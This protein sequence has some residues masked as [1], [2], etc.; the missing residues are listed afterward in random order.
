VAADAPRYLTFRA[1]GILQALPADA[2]REVVKLPALTRVPHAPAGMVGLANVRGAAVPIL[3]PA[4]LQGRADASGERLI[5]LDRAD[6][7]GLLVDEVREIVDRK[8][9]TR[10]LDVEA[11]VGLAL[12]QA[13][14]RVVSAKARVVASQRKAAETAAL[15]LISFDVGGQEFALPLDHVAEVIAMP[16]GI[17]PL[18]NADRAVLGS[19]EHRGALLPILALAALLGLGEGTGETAPR[20]VIAVVRGHRVGLAVKSMKSVLRVDETDIDPVPTV[21]ARRVSEA[22]I[23]AIARIESGRRLVSILAVDQL[24][25]ETLMAHMSERRDD[26]AKGEAEMAVEEIEPFLIFRLGEQRFGLPAVAVEEIVRVPDTLSRLP[27]APAFIEGVMNLRGQAIPVIDQRR[28]FGE[29]ATDRRRRAIVIRMGALRAAFAVD[30]VTEIRRI[31]SADLAPAPGV[32]DETRLF[33]RTALM[34]DGSIIL[35]IEPGELLDSTER[36]MLTALQ[37]DAPAI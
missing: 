22:K 33:D 31:E 34:P 36:D 37:T 9:R 24:V 1:A 32:S 4:A 3:S 12:R 11:L 26:Q 21:I 17:T 6:P 7:I 35:L 15:G 19:I 20:I 2:V 25:S 5:V 10:A 16:S 14:A 13:P 30:E 27:R 8:G 28:R 23:Q 29:G 18:P